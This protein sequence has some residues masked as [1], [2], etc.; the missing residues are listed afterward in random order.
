MTTLDTAKTQSTTHPIRV[1]TLSTIGSRRFRQVRV[2][3]CATEAEAAV[4]ARKHYCGPMER[5]TIVYT[6]KRQIQKR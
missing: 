4:Y 5:P 6:P 3:G 1:V 2:K